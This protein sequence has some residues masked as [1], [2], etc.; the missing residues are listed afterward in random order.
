MM[1]I[2]FE[3]YASSYANKIN[4]STGKV[5]TPKEISEFAGIPRSLTDE[6]AAIIRDENARVMAIELRAANDEELL[7]AL[8]AKYRG[9]IT[10]RQRPSERREGRA[11]A[12]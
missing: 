3:E 2:Y 10:C 5:W 6:F 12:K 11:R 1:Q 8:K 4:P 7:A 9:L